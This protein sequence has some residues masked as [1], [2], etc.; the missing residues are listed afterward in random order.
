[1]ELKDKIAIVTGGAVRIGKA[2]TL[3]LAEMGCHVFIHYGSSAAQAEETR[4]QAA[5]FGVQ[6]AT[7][8]ADLRD[9]AATQTIIPAAIKQF[10]RVDI[11]INNAA[12]FPEADH[13]ATLD[14]PT[15]QELFDINLRAPFLLS[16]AFARH[17]SGPQT[18][19]IININ[20]ARVQQPAPD[21]FVYRLAKGALWNM[22]EIL[23]HELAPHITV[24]AVAL[25]AILS[26]PGQTDSYLQD[27][28][29]KRV[30]L[31]RT[32]HPRLVAENIL[33]LL[34]Q[35]FLTGVTIRVDGGEFL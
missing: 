32:G 33:H 24:N 30:P 5:G 1:M 27:I 31:R 28:A 9:A 21:H 7:Y 8:Q 17:H 22:T 18:G 3:A 12:I 16:Q 29:Q 14:L 25:G 4:Q 35:D 6:A 13:F 20:D 15:W 19:K 10:G 2:I 11:L 23:A 26:P 34:R